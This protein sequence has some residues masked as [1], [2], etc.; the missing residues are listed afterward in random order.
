MRSA[1][2]RNLTKTYNDDDSDY[3]DFLLP[4]MESPS[5]RR[6]KEV[7]VDEGPPMVVDKIL[8]RKFLE[9]SESASGFSE[10]YLVKWRG[11][12]YIHVSWELKSDIE[13]VDSQGKVK[14]KRFLQ[15]PLPPNIFGDASKAEGSGGEGGQEEDDIEYFNPEYAEVHRIISCDNPHT[16]HSL[17]QSVNDLNSMADDPDDDQDEL[18]Y[19]VKWRGLPYNECSWERWGDIKYYTQEVFQFWQRQLPP[20]LSSLSVKHPA[21]QDYTRMKES[22]VF[23]VSENEVASDDELKGEGG[24]MMRDYQ[25]EG[26]N[27]LLWNWWHK[28]PCILADEMGLGKTIQSVCFLHQLRVMST[29]KCSGPFLIVAPLS[30]ISQWQSEIALW[31][32]DMNCV[33][34]HGSQQAKDIILSYEF[35]HHEAF[36]PKADVT[37]LRKQ[38]ACK[39]DILLT[40]YEICLKDIKIF[41]KIDWKVLIVDEA[42]RLKNCQSRL[43]EVMNTI[44]RQQCVLLTGTPLQ[45]KTEELWALL[46]FADPTKFKNQYE[47]VQKFGDLRDANDVANLHALLKPFLLRRV[48]EDVEKTLPPKEEVIVEITLTS[49]QKQFY[50]A[51][52]EKNV[53]YLFRGAKASNTPSLMNVMMELRKCCNHPYLIRGV[54][55][56]LIAEM[57]VEDQTD[58]A[59]HQKLVDCSGKFVLLD[60]LLPRLK[61]EGRKVLIFSQMVKM[62]NLLE[63]F[64]RFKGYLYERL[65]G[66]TRS[67]DR[68]M[69][70]ERFCRPSLKRFVM[71]LSTKAGGLGLNLTS[72]DTVIIF[73]SDW[74]PHNDMQAQAR[75][76]RIGQTKAVKVYRLLTRKTYEMH[77][78]HQASLKLGLDK[79]VLAHARNEQEA[80]DDGNEANKL[81]LQAKEIDE[82]LKRGAYDI[83][84]DDD[85][86]QTEFVEADIDSILS[87]QAHVV[88]MD[89]VSETAMSSSLGGFSKAS[90][91]SADESEDIDIND[92]DFWKK[93][94]GFEE[95]VQEEEV[96]PFIE[97]LPN[98]RVRKQ[99]QAF[100]DTEVDERELEVLL[101]LQPIKKS[102]DNDSKPAK[103]EK[104]PKEPKEPKKKKEKPLK[105]PKEPKEHKDPK[106]WGPH[107][108][109]RMLRALLQFGFGRWKKIRTESGATHRELKDI[110]TFS[111][112]YM[113]QCGFCAGEPGDGGKL[114]S[115]FIEEAVNAAKVFKERIEKGEV[116]MST[117]VPP[118]LQDEKFLL[119]LKGVGSRKMLNKLEQLTRL[120]SLVGEGVT[121]YCTAK[122]PDIESD[123][124]LDFLVAQINDSAGL[125]KFMPL[126]DVRPAWTRPRS[127]WD[128]DCD[129]QLIMGVF[130]HGHG[131]YLEIRDDSN[132]VFQGRMKAAAEHAK[133][134]VSPDS[135][136]YSQIM[137]LVN[138]VLGM[139]TNSKSKHKD[140]MNDDVITTVLTISET[141]KCRCAIA[142]VRHSQYRGVYSQ[143]G[144]TKWMAQYGN[145]TKSSFIGSFDS[146]LEAALAY[147]GLARKLEES[148]EGCNF[149][150]SFPS[151]DGKVDMAS[152]RMNITP[153]PRDESPPLPWHRASR[154]RGVRASGAKWTAQICYEGVN[155]HLGTFSGEY[156]AALSY[157]TSA[158]KHHGDVA[159]LNFP[160][161]IDEELDKLKG[162]EG[163][164]IHY[165]DPATA[166]VELLDTDAVDT[167]PNPNGA[168][169]SMTN[170]NVNDL[171][172]NEDAMDVDSNIEINGTLSASD[173]GLKEMDIESATDNAASVDEMSIKDENKVTD[174]NPQSIPPPVPSSDPDVDTVN[175]LCY[176]ESLVESHQVNGHAVCENKAGS[177]PT[178]QPMSSA[179]TEQPLA[180]SST[181]LEGDLKEEGIDTLV[182]SETIVEKDGSDSKTV[183][184]MEQEDEADADE[185]LDDDDD[186]DDDGNKEKKVK[187]EAV[188]SLLSS[189]EEKLR[190]D[191]LMPESRVL[192]RLFVWLVSSEVAR[193]SR[194]AIE[195]KKRVVS[196]EKAAAKAALQQ[197]IKRRRRR[198]K[199]SDVVDQPDSSECS[200]AVVTVPTQPVEKKTRRKRQSA[201]KPK[202]NGDESS[203]GRAKL[204]KATASAK[205]AVV[206]LGEKDI[207]VM[208]HNIFGHGSY[209]FSQKDTLI[210][211]CE[212]LLERNVSEQPADSKMDTTENAA[213]DEIDNDIGQSTL[214]DSAN[215]LSN[216]EAK[217]LCAAF[218]LYGAPFED[219]KF[220]VY[221]ADIYDL[222]GTGPMDDCSIMIT[223]EFNSGSMNGNDSAVK[224]DVVDEAGEL[225]EDKEL[226][227]ASRGSGDMLDAL[228]TTLLPTADSGFQP[229]KVFQWEKFVELTGVKKPVEVIREF[230]TECWLPFCVKISSV[231]TFTNQKQLPEPLEDI[232]FHSD[233]TKNLSSLFMQRQ[234]MLRTMRYILC[235]YPVPLKTFLRQQAGSYTIGMPVWWCPWIHDIALMVGCLKHGFVNLD[236]ILEDEELPFC[237][238][239][240]ERHINRVFVYG[241]K[242]Q[243]PAA[244]HIFKT[245]E[246]AQRWVEAVALIFP[247]QRDVDN[248]IAQIL[249]EVTKHLPVRHLNRI[250][251]S[252]ENA[253]SQSLSTDATPSGT[254]STSTSLSLQEA[255]NE[256]IQKAAH[257]AAFDS[258]NGLTEWGIRLPLAP[259]VQYVQE[260]A[261]RRRLS[262]A[263]VLQRPAVPQGPV[264]M[265]KKHKRKPVATEATGAG[266]TTTEHKGSNDDDKI[267]KAGETS[268]ATCKVSTPGEVVS[269]KKSSSEVPPA[270]KPWYENS[271]DP[272]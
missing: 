184:N 174:E 117:L 152:R 228:N 261:K 155:H 64:M 271:S 272:I 4:V 201:E 163:V 138:R 216:E 250:Y 6:K 116:Q 23:G 249:C 123:G 162:I 22:P 210:R 73:D 98:Q 11:M 237:T 96:D 108:R 175:D 205:S 234:R 221:T 158:I 60:K 15:S 214:T 260:T 122:N 13:R 34:M 211:E 135:K 97:N 226:E 57:A 245:A 219:T 58:I 146:E 113:L 177:E 40:T 183:N 26:V 256:K 262:L 244:A 154:Y 235:R 258:S 269:Q 161:G 166:P 9:D 37:A 204:G 105:E 190:S 110:E 218:I 38:N 126:G 131:K 121:N 55:E 61:D 127:W 68:N 144:S 254:S 134:T 206:A 101:R 169:S 140:V 17:C 66:S 209:N 67:T 136:G 150:S 265:K 10:M 153:F 232:T 54:E 16:P 52:Y 45:N 20:K 104:E 12:S 80:A 156:Q 236:A 248:R 143:P 5:G 43:F 109:D 142:T 46:H 48:K 30:L 7:V 241:T 212:I 102:A 91:V 79:A 129:K 213:T 133:A 33:V 207:L 29:T 106:T 19:Y 24:L 223:P 72:A 145:N 239:N 224:M 112:S 147:D 199:E 28:R 257:R 125:A 27:W 263:E 255:K 198:K 185:D 167:N 85:T 78:F 215:S 111:R 240:L 179:P 267:T 200:E 233:V 251:N 94:V 74:N 225:D 3:D 159:V 217:R 32:P 196:E 44:P 270:T 25:L 56:R 253:A 178:E 242:T 149:D 182:Q 47:F 18:F 107:A 172:I 92:P 99:T 115:P 120:F 51:I 252:Q 193:Q 160:G 53:Q 82:L 62:L 69:A 264:P 76:H 36:T 39:F 238:E 165:F 103:K 194:A 191:M 139:T 195:E 83:F 130:E 203:T 63:D 246:D 14:I 137:K 164:E 49:F 35:Y 176:T 266:T 1:R 180:T 148:D 71:L 132:F 89:H 119:K 192:N 259:L 95:P 187:K 21:L 31:S 171:N 227:E 222:L 59:M 189:E 8:G 197:G 65:D 247:L 186:D 220:P 70:V 84:R 170:G 231:T 141:K 173:S 81:N 181:P 208:H 243:A 168:D 90:F 229:L 88:S 87:R 124:D 128:E 41:T 202:N 151:I 42:H 157:D 268:S 230:Y 86:E 118:I 188:L 100:G 93:A 50:R 77:M 2:K 75:A 114:D